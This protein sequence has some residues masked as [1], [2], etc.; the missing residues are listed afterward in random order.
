MNLCVSVYERVWICVKIYEFGCFGVCISGVVCEWVDSMCKSMCESQCF[1][2]RAS[3]YVLMH[4]CKS[5]FVYICM[6]FVYFKYIYIVIYISIY[7]WVGLCVHV[8]VVFCWVSIF[9]YFPQS[10]GAS[11]DNP[12]PTFGLSTRRL[13]ISLWNTLWGKS[14]GATVDSDGKDGLREL[15]IVFTRKH[16]LI[17]E[18]SRF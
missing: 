17:Y 2:V 11:S 18:G 6:C 16:V 5:G 8:E 15:Q 7:I 3:E 10:P 1:C 4:V 12:R 14:L 9:S 13:F